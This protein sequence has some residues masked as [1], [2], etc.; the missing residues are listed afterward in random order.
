MASELPKIAIAGNGMPEPPI[1]REQ[2]KMHPLSR[3][4]DSSSAYSSDKRPD[5][6]LHN[7]STLYI[8]LETEQLPIAFI[9]VI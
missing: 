7:P 9:R 6:F 5:I 4:N 8:H 1:T 2:S 3:P